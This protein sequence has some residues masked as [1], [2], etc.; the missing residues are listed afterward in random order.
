MRAGFKLTVVRA[1][2]TRVKTIDNSLLLMAYSFPPSPTVGQIYTS[3]GRTWRWSG[4][5]WTATAVSTPTSA[6]V[7]VSVS[8]PPNPVQGALW[9]DS[10]NSNLNIWYKDL[11]GGQW[12]SVVPYPM[13]TIDQN[14]GVFE[15]PIYAQY[16]IPNNPAAF[17]TSS[18][19]QDNMVQYLELQGYMK[20][21]NGITVSSDGNVIQIDSGLVT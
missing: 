11:N 15:G 9:Y 3:N 7:Y 16:E 2:V 17:V 13:D 12:I 4:V 18:W 20:A 8:P 14:G 6:P 10:N 5:Q 21:G 1:G 19:V